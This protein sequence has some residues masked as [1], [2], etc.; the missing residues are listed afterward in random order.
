MDTPLRL[1][2]EPDDGS[3]RRPAHVECAEFYQPYVAL[4]PDGDLRRLLPVIF[5]AN[6]RALRTIPAEQERD[7]YAP[8]KW[9]I[10][11]TVGHMADTER[12]FAYRALRIARGDTT[13]LA[14]FDEKLFVTAARYDD[15]P[16]DQSLGELMAVHASTI[17]LFE[18]IE[19]EA[20]NRLG[21]ASG[22]PVSVRA[23]AYMIAGHEL[24][25]MQVLRDRYG[26]MIEL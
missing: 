12:V 13:P 20:W 18:N 1:P 5:D 8:G 11:E 25:H 6:Y 3:F 17:L 14:S 15:L 7:R 4:V 19:D 9:S 10:R 24:H 2:V 22:H 21:T 16:L 26:V 23:L